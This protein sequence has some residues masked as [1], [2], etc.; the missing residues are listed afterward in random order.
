MFKN[1]GEIIFGVAIV[2][3]ICVVSITCCMRYYAHKDHAIDH[4]Y[5][6]T[7]VPGYKGKV[8]VREC[9]EDTL[10]KGTNE[11]QNTCK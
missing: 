7:T 11:I 3:A 4:G 10:R 1:T 6:E 2:F 5:V 8:W 9:P